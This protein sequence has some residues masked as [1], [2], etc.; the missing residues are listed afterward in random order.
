MGKSIYN[1]KYLKE[2]CDTNNVILN[3]DYSDIFITRDS[4]IEGKCSNCENS[5]NKILR[6]LLLSGSYC[7]NC[8]KINQKENAIAIGVQAGHSTQSSGAIAIGFNAGLSAEGI[9]SIAIGVQAGNL[10]QGS[11]SIAFGSYA[12]QT[13]QGLYSIS[14]G[15]RAGSS[16]QG[17]SS[18]AIG[19]DSAISSQGTNASP[20]QLAQGISMALYNTAFG[21]LIA[22]PA[23]AGWRYLRNLADARANDLNNATRVLLKNM[24]PQ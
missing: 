9:N 15:Y 20:Q 7:F 19:S 6:R 17:L 13:S 18:I 11:N 16:N 5:F 24:F 2:Y 14:L 10:T 4:E 12:G 3:K 23:I 8:T 22:I 1:Y 21:L